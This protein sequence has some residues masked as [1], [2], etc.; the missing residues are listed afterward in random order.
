MLI[1]PIGYI[2]TDFKEKFGIPRQSGRSSNSMG[3]IVF[4]PPYNSKDAFRGLEEF[5]HI[6]IVFGFSNAEYKEKTLTV[7]PPR[8]GGNK[9]MGVFAT[10]SPFR[11][12]SLGLSSVKLE[13][14]KHTNSGT[15]LVVSGVDLLDN[16]PVYD[17]KPY[18]PLT[19]SHPNAKGGYSSE[20]WPHKLDVIFEK[21]LEDIMPKD[22]LKA[23]VE[24]LGD[25][26]RPSYQEDGRHYNMRYAC[27]DVTF[28]VNGNVLTVTNIKEDV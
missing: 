5:S 15:T 9:R 28:N 25:D 19:D 26:P 14:I 24:C 1:N 27:Y 2:K 21:G 10:R 11:P 4:N 23:L 20:N 13:Q 17:I 7:R 22:K 3:E 8:L 6:W 18:L 16:T 12:N